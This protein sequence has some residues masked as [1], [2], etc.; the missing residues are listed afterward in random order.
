MNALASQVRSA[1]ADTADKSASL[2]M[3]YSVQRSAPFSVLASKLLSLQTATS[4]PSSVSPKSLGVKYQGK[5]AVD[6]S[7]TIQPQV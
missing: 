4:I 1:F 5:R 6:K 2:R 7:N 3:Q